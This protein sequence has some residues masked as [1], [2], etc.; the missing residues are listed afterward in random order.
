[1]MGDG[2]VWSASAQQAILMYMV[3]LYS[4]ISTA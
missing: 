1:M 4:S 3:C 2:A